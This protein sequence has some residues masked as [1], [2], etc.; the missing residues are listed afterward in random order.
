MKKRH[1]PYTDIHFALLYELGRR[2]I[3]GEIKKA[4]AEQEAALRDV[5]KTSAGY[6]IH[7]HQQLFKGKIYKRAMSAD[8]Y[9]FYLKRIYDDYGIDQLGLALKALKEHLDYRRNKEVEKVYYLFERLLQEDVSA[10]SFVE[11]QMV[12][13]EGKLIAVTH[14]LRERDSRVVEL[15][16]QLHYEN[17]PMMKCECCGFSYSDVY[18][19]RGRG[20]IEA[21]HNIPIS[22]LTTEREVRPEDFSM[23]CAN[24]HRMIH[25]KL[26]WLR[27]EELKT[28]IIENR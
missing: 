15:A 18:G 12:Y 8:A 4:H 25:K 24:C 27:V 20:F 14:I 17:D 22:E 19:S 5:D 26:P 7:I 2:V 6:F 21:H 9:S 11:S 10:R 28:I 13:T 16:K 23:L 3:N 1:E